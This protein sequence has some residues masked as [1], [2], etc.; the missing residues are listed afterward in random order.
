MEQKIST[1][2][3]EFINNRMIKKDGCKILSSEL[4]ESFRQYLLDN[5]VP[6]NIIMSINNT[7][8]TRWMKQNY[9]DLI[10]KLTGAGNCFHGICL[11]ENHKPKQVIPTYGQ[12]KEKQALY[13]REYY[14]K[15]KSKINCELDAEFMRRTG[16]KKKIF[17]LM[18]RNGIIKYIYKDNNALSPLDIVDWDELRE[19]QQ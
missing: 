2:M 17:F 1:Y 11:I 14:K 5:K 13:H 7:L 15:N 16:I 6:Y 3:N 10:H 8:V 12:Y 18:R 9:P 19:N 4:Y